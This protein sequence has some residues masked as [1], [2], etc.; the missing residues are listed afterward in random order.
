MFDIRTDRR[1][2]GWR[3][4]VAAPLGAVMSVGLA[5]CGTSTD[6]SATSSAATSASATDAPTT[7]QDS[8]TGSTDSQMSAF[9]S[10]M[11][12]NGVTL[13][14]RPNGRNG[15][16]PSGAPAAPPDGAQGDGGQ[17]A[18]GPGG[19]AGGTPGQAPPGV[20]ATK[21]AAAQQAC[22]GVAPQRP[23]AGT[24]GG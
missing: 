19:G 3:R 11:A 8:A 7:A 2:G 9:P 4:L 12:E 20:D 10:C 14:E 17:G 18:G 15:T 5:A 21:W 22:A 16:R 24:A 23:D 13:P 6:A 1:S